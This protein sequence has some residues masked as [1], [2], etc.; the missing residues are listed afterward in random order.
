LDVYLHGKDRKKF[1]SIKNL[2][3]TE[4]TTILVRMLKDCIEEKDKRL[5]VKEIIERYQ[6]ELILL[7][8]YDNDT[9]NV[10]GLANS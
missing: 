8:K 7:S 4:E 5:S 6:K 10:F 3:E 1:P 9:K 2:N